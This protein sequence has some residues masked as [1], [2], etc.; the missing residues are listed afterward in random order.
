MT[1]KLVRLPGMDCPHCGERAIARS[2]EPETLISRL[3]R[4]R[5]EN[6]FCGHTFVAQL[7]ILRTVVPSTRPNPEVRLPLCNPNLQHFGPRH[8]NDDH[9][10]PANDEGDPR[11]G[12]T[13]PMTG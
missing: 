6:D 2:S 4:Y 5:C 3:L 12:V 7:I 10:T 13:Q 8:A 1:A 9:R 11:P